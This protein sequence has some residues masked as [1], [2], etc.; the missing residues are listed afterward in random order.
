MH[1]FAQPGGQNNTWKIT[2][3]VTT[4]DATPVNIQWGNMPSNGSALRYFVRAAVVETAGVSGVV[5]FQEGSAARNASGSGIR[6]FLDTPDGWSAPG[7]P[8]F[9]L[10]PPAVTF[11]CAQ[12]SGNAVQTNFVGIAATTFRWQAWIDVQLW[13]GATIP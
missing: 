4:T 8:W 2:I 11:T 1:V 5:L 6:S 12:L 3:D 9:T 10:V 13:G 7:A